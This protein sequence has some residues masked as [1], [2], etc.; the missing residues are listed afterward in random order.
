MKSKKELWH[1]DE[2]N[3]L[4]LAKLLRNPLLQV[5][6]EV[7]LDSVKPRP[8]K[9]LESNPV[10]SAANY[11]KQAGYNDAFVQLQYLAEEPPQPAAATPQAWA[12]HADKIS[13]NE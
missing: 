4:E 5:A 10:A 7:V 3:R 6:I 9:E 1:A 11:H 2:A 12:H 13:T 8:S